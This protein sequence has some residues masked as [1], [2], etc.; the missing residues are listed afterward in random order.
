MAPQ[1]D[2]KSAPDA[3]DAATYQKLDALSE[4]LHDQFGRGRERVMEKVRA[5]RA[6]T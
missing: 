6:R 3:R 2:R 5:I 4:V 1:G